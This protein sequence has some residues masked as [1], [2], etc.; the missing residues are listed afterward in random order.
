MASLNYL[1]GI[2][3]S[4]NILTLNFV[5]S[6]PSFQFHQKYHNL[7]EDFPSYHDWINYSSLYLP[8]T[9]YFPSMTLTI[10]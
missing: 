9:L 7:W 4:L 5:N 2:V 6:Y 10:L 1:S 8:S 3:S